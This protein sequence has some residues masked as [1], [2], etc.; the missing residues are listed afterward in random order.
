MSLSEFIAQLKQRKDIL[1]STFENH[2]VATGNDI[3]QMVQDRIQSK[4]IGADGV[5]FKDYTQEYKKRK[6]KEG[7]LKNVVDY[8]LTS[9]MWSDVQQRIKSVVSA[10]R[11]YTVII[12]PSSN[13]NVGKFKGLT[14]RDGQKPTTPSNEE[15]QIAKENLVINIK[16]EL[17]G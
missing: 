13:E 10:G 7:K 1:E 4:G 12:G 5:A 14:E 2:V 9:R 15:I 16:L 11:K 6:A 8:T 17:F 3:L